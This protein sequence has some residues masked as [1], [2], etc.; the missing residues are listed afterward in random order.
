M[1]LRYRSLSFKC[2]FIKKTHKNTCSMGSLHNIHVWWGITSFNIRINC[3]FHHSLLQLCLC[4]QTPDSRLIT[5]FS[6]LICSIQILNMFNKNLKEY[7]YLYIHKFFFKKKGG[8]NVSYI[9]LERS[10]ISVKFLIKIHFF[11]FMI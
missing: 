2:Q 5:S 10:L 6:K 7:I 3:F 9:T 11:N 4:K 8:A 1:K